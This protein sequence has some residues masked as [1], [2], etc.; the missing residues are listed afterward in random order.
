MPFQYNINPLA[1]L[2]Q[3]GSD[4]GSLTLRFDPYDNQQ[5]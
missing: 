5:V 4:L 2:E 3:L 1:P